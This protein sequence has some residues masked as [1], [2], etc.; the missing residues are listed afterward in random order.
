MILRVLNEPDLTCKKVDKP[1][2]KVYA[3]AISQWRFKQGMSVFY[4]CLHKRLKGQTLGKERKRDLA[5]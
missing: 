2:C 4:I 1:G 5:A 3:Q